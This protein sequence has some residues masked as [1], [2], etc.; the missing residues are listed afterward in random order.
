[1]LNDVIQDSLNHFHS[2]FNVLDVATGKVRYS[3]NES[4]PLYHYYSISDEAIASVDS[5]SHSIIVSDFGSSGRRKVGETVGRCANQN[6]PTLYTDE[7]LVYGCDKLIVASTDGHVLMTDAFASGETSSDK[8]AAA[9]NGRFLTLA[10]NTI[11]V[12]NHFLRESSMRITATR[13]VVYDLALRKRVLTVNVNPLPQNDYDFAMSPDGS[14]LAVLND[15]DVSVYAVPVH[16]TDQADNRETSR[17]LN[18]WVRG[19]PVTK[20]LHW[21]SFDLQP[22]QRSREG[23]SLPVP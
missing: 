8:T 14:K 10:L 21:T 1:M 20:L 11:E 7:Q 9:Q 12:K 4:P 15:R 22:V 3:W 19:A 17:S 18:G 5:D 2:H 13:L 6:M 16:P 23:T